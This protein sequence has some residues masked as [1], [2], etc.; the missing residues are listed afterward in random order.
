MHLTNP[1][2]TTVITRLRQT[3]IIQLG[4]SHTYQIYYI[5]PNFTKYIRKKYNTT[6]TSPTSETQNRK[7]RQKTKIIPTTKSVP[8]YKTPSPKTSS[9][10]SKNIN[11][12]INS[13]QIP[14]KI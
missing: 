8:Q 2:P 11:L 6:T 12:L 14:K 10:Y 3:E 9:S 1:V 13:K 5:Q 7:L 4:G